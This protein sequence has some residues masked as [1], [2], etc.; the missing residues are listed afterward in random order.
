MTIIQINY[1]VDIHFHVDVSYNEI[2][3]TTSGSI[4]GNVGGHEI[5]TSFSVTTPQVQ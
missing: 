5:D 3:T 4:V 1:T 2:G